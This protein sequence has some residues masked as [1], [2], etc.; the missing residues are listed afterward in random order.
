MI[1]LVDVLEHLPQEEGQK[2]L[3]EIERVS[4]NRIIST[5]KEF[6]PQKAEYSNPAEK[7]LSHWVYDDFECL[8]NKFFL[9]NEYS[10]ILF[11]GEKANIIKP[12]LRYKVYE[13]RNI[14]P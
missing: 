9:E 8:E 2:L 7:H 3:H 1:L 6:S 5:P 13:N 11:W 4:K 10:I 14:N 12:L